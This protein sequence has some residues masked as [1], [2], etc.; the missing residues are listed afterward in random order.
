MWDGLLQVVTT[1]SQGKV[2]WHNEKLNV[3][4]GAGRFVKMPLFPPLFDGLDRTD[5]AW[6]S[7]SFPYGTTP[8]KREG[9]QPSAHDEL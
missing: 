6:L 3:T 5:A 9:D 2:V 1:I 8:V 7:M 4:A